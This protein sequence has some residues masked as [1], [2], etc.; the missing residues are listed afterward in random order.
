[1]FKEDLIDK[2]S[3][4]IEEGSIYK[5]QWNSQEERHGKGE[6][7]FHNGIYYEGYWK[8]G[9]PDILGRFIYTE[10]ILYEG[11]IQEELPNGKGV[12]VSLNNY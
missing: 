12:L 10:Q 8:N 9:V 3:Y 11:Q 1:M 4:L 2:E 6:C 5:G 7:M